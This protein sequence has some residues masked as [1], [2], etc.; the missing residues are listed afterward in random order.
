LGDILARNARRFGSKPSVIS[1]AGS[2]SYRLLN[3]RVNCL[4]NGLLRNGLKKGDRLAVLVHNSNEILEIYFSAAKTGAIFCPYNNHLTDKELADVINY[5]TPRFLFFHRDYMEK[6]A[7]AAKNVSSVERY[8]CLDGSIHPFAT[9][10]RELLL[11]GEKDEPAIPI[12]DDDPVSL[13]FTA[14]TTGKPKGAIHTHRHVI[15]NGMAG[16]IEQK[17]TYDERVLISNPMYHV[18]CEDNIGRHTFLPNTLVIRREGAFNPDAILGQIERDKITRCQFVPTMIVSLLQS[19]NIKSYDLSSLALILYTSAPMPVD[20][21]RQALDRFDC[22]FAQMYGQTESGPTV[23]IL[24][25]QDHVRNPTEQQL[26][27]LGSVG[28]PIFINEAR[29]VDSQDNDVDAGEFGEIIVKSEA[30]MEGYWE[31]PRE[32]EEKLRGGWLHTGDLGRID[33]DGYLYVVGRKDDMIISGGVNIYPREV[34]EVLYSHPGIL[35]AAVIGVPDAYW[36]EALKAVVIVKPGASLS[37]QEVI[38]FCGEHMAGFKKPKSVDFW[39]ELP[40]SPQG[41]ILKKEIRKT[42]IAKE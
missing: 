12:L 9:D 21:L 22:P 32:T 3:E 35:E 16:V 39:Q 5:S 28:K 6:L 37:A 7:A 15:I 34:E 27:R 23:S 42:F 36:G 24:S 20:L 8:F 11:S 4:S 1:E 14:G 26:V 18:S 33:T 13:F 29:I 31:L 10:Y 19:P 30:I 41:K 17:V 25:P 2:I 40:K 38:E